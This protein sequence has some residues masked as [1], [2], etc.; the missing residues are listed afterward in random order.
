MPEGWGKQVF[1][2]DVSGMGDAEFR[3]DI[4]P[5]MAPLSWLGYD[6]D[7]VYALPT[8]YNAYGAYVPRR[9]WAGS[10]A[11]PLK[12]SE[13]GT[14]GQQL[15]GL[16][17][18][19]V[20]G[21]FSDGDMIYKNT[22]FKRTPHHQLHTYAHEFTHRGEKLLLNSDDPKIRDQYQLLALDPKN[23]RY[24]SGEP[25][26]ENFVRLYDRRAQ[27]G[28]NLNTTHNFSRRQDLGSP[29]F[30]NFANKMDEMAVSELAR[31]APHSFPPQP[32]YPTAWSSLISWLKE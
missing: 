15:L 6:P 14:Y 21:K 17:E 32:V 28:K 12:L 1:G 25:G 16:A 20:P 26:Q 9:G 10:P 7:R 11:N 29:S 31:T 27:A 3:A 5:F 23:E 22:H 13:F 8:N 18:E 4:E 24:T 2:Q 19:D 30:H